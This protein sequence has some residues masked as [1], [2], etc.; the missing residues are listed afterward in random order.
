MSTLCHWVDATARLMATRGVPTISVT[1]EANLAA[2]VLWSW[3][4]KVYNSWFRGLVGE[5]GCEGCCKTA[6]VHL[7][8]AADF[9]F[10]DGQTEAGASI[11]GLSYIIMKG[12]QTGQR[13]GIM[14]RF[15][16]VEGN[17]MKYYHDDVVG[18]GGFIAAHPKVVAAIPAWSHQPVLKSQSNIRGIPAAGQ[19]RKK[20]TAI[21]TDYDDLGVLHPLLAPELLPTQSVT[22]PADGHEHVQGSFGLSATRAF[23]GRRNGCFGLRYRR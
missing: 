4:F 23:R 11:A 12:F 9:L 5:C 13:Q 17:V 18:F 3:S 1:E 16:K 22:A 20:N 2:E 14:L 15:T 21:A 10:S 19:K 6:T 7:E 8:G